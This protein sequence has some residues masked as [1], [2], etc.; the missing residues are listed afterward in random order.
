MVALQIISDVHMEFH[1]DGGRSFLETLPV[2]SDVLVVAGDLAVFRDRSR[3]RKIFELLCR[4]RKKVYFVLGNHE[5]YGSLPRTVDLLIET[6]EKEIPNLC[7]LRP[8]RVDHLDGRRVLGATLWFR[9]DPMNAVYAPQ[10]NDF[11]TIKKFVPWV[12]E[13]NA[14]ALRFFEKEL[15]PDDIVITHHLPS[16]RSVHSAYSGSTINRFFL[17]DVEDLLL[18]RKPALWVH[19]HC[20]SPFDYFIDSCRVVANPLGYPREASNLTF[21]DKLVVSV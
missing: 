7:V 13:Q 6:I 21:N 10:L 9:D 20:H 8:G 4:N 1:A 16:S 11:G 14:A 17:C 19:G 5:Y 2:T 12:Y 18:E 3:V 15:Q